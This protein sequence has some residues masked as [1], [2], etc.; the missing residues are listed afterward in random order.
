MRLKAWR[1]DGIL[2]CRTF[3]TTNFDEINCMLFPSKCYIIK[4]ASF[5][6]H[7][8]PKKIKIVFTIKLSS[9]NLRIHL[10]LPYLKL[11]LVNL[12]NSFKKG[13]VQ[14]NATSMKEASSDLHNLKAFNW[15]TSNEHL[16]SMM[17]IKVC[18]ISLY[19]TS[20]SRMM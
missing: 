3:T 1:L 20:S 8:L 15:T 4:L 11:E 13:L 19:H 14:K 6:Y 18:H 16:C 17:A 7:H 10:T 2:H 12:H 9:L 5:I